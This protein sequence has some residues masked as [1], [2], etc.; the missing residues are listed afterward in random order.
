MNDEA[1]AKQ[2]LATPTA[3]LRTLLV[4]AKPIDE[5]ATGLKS[6]RTF[7]ISILPMMN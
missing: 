5:L 4:P 2:T 1:T 6:L 7:F 3:L